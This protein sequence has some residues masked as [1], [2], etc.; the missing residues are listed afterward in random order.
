MK[1]AISVPD[2]DFERFDR[3][4]TRFGMT[5]SEFYRVA[6]QKLADELE[7][8]GK[9][10]LTRLADAAIAEVGQPSAGGEFL[11]ESERIAR[12]GSEW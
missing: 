6:G 4:A 9:A 10:E 2:S 3:V 1:T 5:R 11:R 8:A 12:T 7:G